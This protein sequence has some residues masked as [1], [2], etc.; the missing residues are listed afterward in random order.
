MLRSFFV[1]ASAVTL[2]AGTLRAQPARDSIA[3]PDIPGFHTLKGDLHLHT[4]FSD[5]SVW[6]TFRVFEARRDGLD[7]IALTDH[8]DYQGSPE[9]VTGDL[10]TAYDLAAASAKG[11][12]LI[13]I[14]GAEISPRTPPYHS[15][16]LFLRDASAIPSG[17]ML[18]TKGK[19]VMKEHPSHDE[20][21]APFIEAKKQGAFITYNHPA[22]VYDWDPKYIGTDLFT[23]FHR[24]MLKNGMLHGIE[25]VNSNRYYKPAHRIAMENNLTMVAGSDEHSDIATTY[26]DGHRLMTLVFAKEISADGIREALFARRTA[27]YFRD[28]VIGRKAELE[29][30]FKAALTVTT[31]QS[32]RL[33]EPIVLVH[34]RNSSDIPFALRFGGRYEIDNLPLGRITLAPRGITTIALRTLWE[35]PAEISI[36]A[37]VENLLTG[38]DESLETTLRVRPAWKQ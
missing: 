22:Y 9:T 4:V 8:T 15:N 30:F 14:K 25:I 27:V 35:S 37:T 18:E 32:K 20:L 2:S 17:Y 21:M 5:G 28:L 33:N 29:P 19:F 31:E 24:E 36:E 1:W 38:P 26:P 6:P 34:I 13:V 3:L 7:F 10:N 12:K 16:A 23:A 11:S